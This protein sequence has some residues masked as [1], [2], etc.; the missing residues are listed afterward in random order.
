M[1]TEVADFYKQKD[2]K[3]ERITYSYARFWYDNPK[4]FRTR[5]YEGKELPSNPAYQF[6]SAISDLIKNE[7]EHPLFKDLPR[8]SMVD[9]EYSVL[10]G[11][12]PFVFHPDMFEPSTL[13]FREIKT[14]MREYGGK[15]SWTQDAVD[16]HM[17]LDCYSLGIETLFGQVNEVCHLD[18]L[19]KDKLPPVIV[20]SG[21]K[22]KMSNAGQI[23]FNGEVISFERTITPLE[24]YRAKEWLVQAYHEIVNDFNNFKKNQ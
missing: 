2:W 8:Y 14:G 6:G 11:D 9:E 17:Q 24:R 5:Y 10:L 1:S 22:A 23:V 21:K 19:I 16:K 18:W 3:P 4:A 12:V 7:P 15:P 20:P 13:S